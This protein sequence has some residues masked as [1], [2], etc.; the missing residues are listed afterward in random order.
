VPFTLQV[1]VVGQWKTVA[2]FLKISAVNSSQKNSD[3]PLG[4][5][6]ILIPF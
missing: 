3:D 6:E 1:K 2:G 5:T 4:D